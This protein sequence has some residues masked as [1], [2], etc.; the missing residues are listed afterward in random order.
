M[1]MVES[2]VWYEAGNNPRMMV[3]N[4]SSPM[5]VPIPASSLWSFTISI[6][7]AFTSPSSSHFDCYNLRLVS[8]WC[9]LLL[10]VA[11]FFTASHISFTDLRDFTVKERQIEIKKVHTPMESDAIFMKDQCPKT[12]ISPLYQG[13]CGPVL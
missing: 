10:V 5:E 12:S 13:A 4:S 7:C 3:E 11:S 1:V 2:K 6:R 8:T 9:I